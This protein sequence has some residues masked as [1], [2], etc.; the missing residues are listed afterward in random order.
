MDL[1]RS[2]CWSPT[3]GEE[4]RRRQAGGERTVGLEG[5]SGCAFAGGV[6]RS[7]RGELKGPYEGEERAN[8]GPVGFSRC[9]S[10][11]CMWAG[12][13]HPGGWCASL[14]LCNPTTCIT[15]FVHCDS[16]LHTEILHSAKLA[17]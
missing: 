16:T 1:E 3:A 8:R 5:G 17:F 7:R 9:R 4:V 2:N 12:T 14:R 13:S 15:I 11:L 10:K 6:G